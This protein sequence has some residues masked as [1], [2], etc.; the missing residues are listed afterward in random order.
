MVLVA[1]AVPCLLLANSPV[2]QQHAVAAPENAMSVSR[3]EINDGVV[4]SMPAAHRRDGSLDAFDSTIWFDD[5]EGSRPAWTPEDLTL[6]PLYW[7]LDSRRALGGT[8]F[9]WA[10]WD[11]ATN[12]YADH[13]LQY[14]VTPTLDLSA[15]SNPTLA[16]KARWKTE[17][18]VGATA[19]YDSWDGWNMWVSTDN[20]TNWS[21]LQPT[22]PSYTALHAFS[23]GDIWGMGPDI[24][25]FSYTEGSNCDTVYQPMVFDLS[26]YRTANV[27]IRWGFASDDGFSGTDDP[28]YFG[29]A[30]D[31]IRLV[32]GANTVFSNDGTLDSFTRDHNTPIGQNWVYD[33]VSNHSPTHEWRCTPT[34]NLLCGVTSSDIALPALG[35]NQ[36]LSL[37]YWVWADQP[38]FQG[39]G[40]TLADFY[41]VWVVTPDST[42]RVAYD[43]AYNDGAP[44]PGGNSLNGWVFRTR[45]LTTGGTQLATIDLSAYAGRTIKLM[46]RVRY[47][48]QDTTGVGTGVHIDDIAV[49]FTRAFSNDLS[50]NSVVVKFPTTVGLPQK[51]QF[52]VK[53]EG[54]ANQGPAIRSRVKFVKPDGTIQGIDS[55]VVL[56]APLIP[57]QDTTSTRVWTPAV[58]GS[59][60][61]RVASAQT[62]DED[63]TNDTTYT[64]INVPLNSDSNFAVTVR[65]A[66]Q[67]ELAYHLRDMTS[68]LLNPRY[69][70]YTPLADGV[71]SATV[72]A[73]DITTVRIMWQFDANIFTLP[74]HVAH[75]WVEFWQPGADT[76][77]PGA[78]INRIEVA[79]DTNATIGAASKPH[80]WTLNTA[81]VP[82]LQNRSGDFWV[83]ITPKDSIAGEALPHIMGKSSLPASYDGHN[84]TLRI[85]TVGTPLNPSPSRFCVQTTI[86][87]T[88]TS[89]PAAVSD[90][91][92][93]RVG[94]TDDVQLNWDPAARATG[95]HVY[96][97]TSIGQNYL[98]GTRLT[99]LPTTATSFIDTGVLA[100]G[101]KFFYVVVAIN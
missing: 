95:Y 96:R 11:S 13:W 10:C 1:L 64:A 62:V 101:L 93:I 53:N 85:D 70:R 43:Y 68:A 67:Y 47:D 21:I 20:G 30:V 28:T 82:G 59:Y 41:D 26:A 12:H 31:S 71:P 86:V 56:T 40:N 58:T 8:G 91:T 66:G 87:P 48:G 27:K 76:A 19:P 78:L 100:S 37:R 22:S 65:P 17:Q 25:V 54:L 75:A 39:A 3:F 80:W 77:H 29:L 94:Y 18:P 44:A 81:G 72:N 50:C 55:L 74:G 34:N 36:T 57:G 79:I 7:H 90:L 51:Y 46:Y 99:A 9:A 32:D 60:R 24:P 88:T 97:M 73:H 23:W 38:G 83:S 14:L 52:T 69:V 6:S 45:G 5:F 63:R 89:T 49:I 33:Q 61:V 2:T 98:T 15:T 4:S 16:F 35:A 42:V 92:A 84:Y